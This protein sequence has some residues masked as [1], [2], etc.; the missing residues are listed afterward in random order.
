VS[1]G[2]HIVRPSGVRK[3]WSIIYRDPSG[4]QR[5]EGKFETR[6]AAQ[7]RLTEVLGEIDKGTYARP[8]SITFE[9][10]AEDWL[11]S[12]RQIRGSTDGL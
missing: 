2:G 1:Q 12:R 10:F 11:A 3:T 9:R 6:G 8:S 5:W 7:H 4:L